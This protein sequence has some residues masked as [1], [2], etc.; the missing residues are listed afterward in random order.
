[1]K[2]Y[3]VVATIGKYQK[4]GQEKYINRNVGAVIQTKHGFKLKLDSHF[5][6]AGLDKSEDGGVWLSLFEPKDRQQQQSAPQQPMQQA[7]AQQ[8]GGYQ[9]QPPAQ[10][11]APQ[12]Q[13]NAPAAPDMDSFDDD[14]PF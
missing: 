2:K 5:N 1:M 8:Q 9:Q 11:H 10:Q 3:D 14:I 12:H 13:N 4:D 6:P 7:P